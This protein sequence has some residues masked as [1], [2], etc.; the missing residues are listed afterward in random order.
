MKD[1]FII[2]LV[3]IHA[4]GWSQ[5]TDSLQINVPDSLRL[6]TTFQSDS[7]QRDSTISPQRRSDIETTINYDSKDSIRFNAQSQKV[8]MYG[9]SYI[10]Y[11]DIT[12]EAERTEVDWSTRIIHASYITDS[13]GSAIGKPVYTDGPDVYATDDIIYNFRTRR[14]LIK[15]VVTQ[16]DEA[17]MHG[18]DVKKNSRD[19]LFIKGASYTTCDLAEPHFEIKSNKLK[20]IPGNKVVS[21][22]FNLRFRD[23]P[24]PLFFAFGMFPQPKKK[25]S[26]IV[27]PS[28][29]EE[30]RRGFFLREGGYYFAINDYID[31]RITGDIYS[32]GGNA[33]NF[34]SNYYKRYA[35]RGT[36]NFSYT[37]TVTDNVENPLE[38][39]DYWARWNHSPQS[40]GNSSISASVSAGTSTYNSNN[41]LINQDFS[42]S[43]NSQ[44][45]SNISY[46]NSLPRTPFNMSL[47]LR[48]SQNLQTRIVNLTLPDFTL[49]MNRIY[50]FK[51]LI[52]SSKS[53]LAKLN[54]SHNFVS[55]NEINNGPINE[56]SGF[57][58]A[59]SNPLADSTLAFKSENFDA[60]LER[61]KVGGQHTIPIS[62]SLTV[63]KYF[64]LNPSF[65]YRELWYTKELDYTFIPEENA[66]RV[67]T[68]D[69]F[70]RAG[71]WTSSASLNT[72]VYGYVAFNKGKVQAI[73]HV[74]TPS[75][76]F[77][78][79]PD[80]SDPKYGVYK[81]V[82]IDTTSTNENNTRVLSKY[83]GFIFGSPPGGESKTLGFSLSNNLEMKVVSRKDTITGSKKIKIFDNLG[84]STGYNL[85]A[86]SFKLSNINFNAR[87]S[88]FENKVS[89]NF[90]GTLDPYEYLLI[91]E[92]FNPD[93]SR[94]V[95]QRRR[96]RYTW[97]N[98]NGLGNLS[99][100]NISVGINLRPKK[101]KDQTRDQTG[102]GET[103]AFQQG[104]GVIPPGEN[105]NYEGYTDEE[106]EEIRR[107]QDNPNEYI[108]FNVPWTL[109][110]QYSIN[111]T[112]TGFADPN[113][114][115]SFQFSGSLGLTD[116]TQI[117]FNSGYDF[118][119][120]DFT[121]TR[122][123]IN[124]DLHCWSMSFDWV[125]FGRFQSYFFSIQVKSSV[126]K[127]LK[128]DKRRSF[129][130]FFN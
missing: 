47:N 97:N 28:Y 67:D 91:S 111:R 71:S 62:T 42:R 90:T 23:L 46:R 95:T 122:I 25:A 102:Y 112:Q 9:E 130:D 82:Q 78:Y 83:Q 30:N 45:A 31:A 13:T 32:K 52:K 93:G 116:K 77:S 64:T 126:L 60:I 15:G 39:N 63:L 59:N 54:F 6:A 17:F 8:F 68:V 99:N 1:S 40:K 76:S 18:E 84:M 70:S 16:Q 5:D 127:D 38:T 104:T 108:D 34:T 65:N 115:Q 121:T 103:G 36:F 74:M 14:A 43:I 117:T 35:Y 48:H 98:G 109:R 55:R 7:I 61:S 86:D 21:G 80:F 100:M 2:L 44:F 57:T 118:E 12:L 66:V 124:R 89:V 27:F 110:M 56:P 22:P 69:G 4:I 94:N 101:K 41:N 88:L 113:V 20:V 33:L 75:V 72:R 58:I 81:E 87:T 120:K 114:R 119:A 106:Q 26:G 128:W 50:P 3:L 11:G 24:T 105:I 29:G 107:I 85:A 96:D 123:G 37:K 73:R 129:F 79:S 53:P 19:E 10:D 92:R 49:N 51:K 125:P